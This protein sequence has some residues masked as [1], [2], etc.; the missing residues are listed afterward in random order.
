MCE[1]SAAV[2]LQA[3]ICDWGYQTETTGSLTGASSKF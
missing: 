3:P 1:G 2:C